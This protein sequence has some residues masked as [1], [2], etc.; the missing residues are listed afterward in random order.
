MSDEQ[1]IQQAV[2]AF[3][4]LSGDDV[5]RLKNLNTKIQNHIGA[6]GIV[7]GGNKAADGTVEMRWVDKDPLIYELLDFMDSKGLLPLFA[8]S[9]WKEGIELFESDS[10]DKYDSVDIATAL[11]LIYAVMRKDRFGDGTLVWAF[12]SGG[13]VKLVKQ[14]T[15]LKNIQSLV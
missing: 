2:E 10:A 12:E 1:S 7:K 6:W 15:N 4:N 13:F 3:R 9:D 8:W 14:L 11:K 5:E